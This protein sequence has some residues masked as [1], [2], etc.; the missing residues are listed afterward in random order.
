MDITRP[1]QGKEIRCPTEPIPHI[2]TTT[3][4]LNQ[5]RGARP[6]GRFTVCVFLA[7]I[8]QRPRAVR[9]GIGVNAA[10]RSLPNVVKDDATKNTLAGLFVV[11]DSFN[12]F[13]HNKN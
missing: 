4:R 10:R 13:S 8:W 2:K 7:G 1:A 3:A 11:L 6:S 9:G 12:F 5:E